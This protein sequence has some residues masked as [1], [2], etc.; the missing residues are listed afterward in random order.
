MQ[1]RIGAF[2]ILAVGAAAVAGCGGGGAPSVPQTV[3]Q[4]SRHSSSGS[5]PIAHVVIVVQENRTFNDFFA[6][7]PGADGTTVGNA[8]ANPNCS[9]PISQGTINLKKMPLVLPHDLDHSYLGYLTA[10]DGGLMDGFDKVPRG[11]PNGPP[12]CT[13]PYQYTDP[14]QILPYWT[15]ASQ[16]ALAEHMFTTQ[17]SDSFTAHQD[18][19]RGNT[20]VDR[21]EAMIDLPRCGLCYWGC[22][23]PKGATTH[24]I[25]KT[26]QYLKNEKVFPCTKNFSSTYKTLRDLLDAKGI[27]WKYYLPGPKQIYGKLLSAFDVIW[28]VRNGPEWKNNVIYPQTQILSDISGGTLPAVSWVIP[29]QNDS[30]HPGTSKDTGPSWVASIVN[31]IGQSPYW[32]SSAIII[33]WDDWGGLYDNYPP[34]IMDYGGLGFRVS[35][36]IVSPYA[37]PGYISHTKYEFGSILRYIEGNWNLGSLNTTD[38]RANSMIESFYYSQKPI[39]FKKIP[40]QYSEEYFIH[41]KPSGLPPDTDM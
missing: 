9:P 12:E 13:Y 27:S 40:S 22:D 24:L 25:T 7:Y 18:L 41:E 37:K 29:D 10:Y 16:Y 20:V 14:S 21:N 1:I 19:I 15:M 32:N 6:T 11:G 8:A 34:Q 17:G 2:F 36:L 35:A 26:N 31:A 30:D 28:A 3:Q 38:R 23:S 5:S 39:Q 4:P 33:V